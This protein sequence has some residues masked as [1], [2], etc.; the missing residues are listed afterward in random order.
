MVV[1]P[2]AV[3]ERLHLRL[4]QGMQVLEYQGRIRLLPARD[5]RALGG[6]LKGIGTDSEREGDRARP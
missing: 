1:I 2:L 4:G 3:R 5:I 6:L